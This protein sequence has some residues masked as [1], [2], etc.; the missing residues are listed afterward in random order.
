MN[1]LGA[2]TL[3]FLMTNFNKIDFLSS[4]IVHIFH[5]THKAILTLN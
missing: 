2:K 4:K 1:I 5:G 3:I